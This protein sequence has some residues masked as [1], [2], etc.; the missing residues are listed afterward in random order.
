MRIE[1]L[2]DSRLAQ[3]AFALEGSTDAGS[4]ASMS[5]H[6]PDKVSRMLAKAFYREM[7]HCGFTPNQIIHAA[8]EIISELTTSLNR[9][10]NRIERG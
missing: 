4:V 8:G 7:R 2:L 6:E 1:R 3:M 9:A 10:K 5:A